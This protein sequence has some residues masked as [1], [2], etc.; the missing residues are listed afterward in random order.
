A[1]WSGS[2]AASIASCTATPAPKPYS[3]T[4]SAIARPPPSWNNPTPAITSSPPS[5]STSS[6]P[7]KNLCSTTRGPMPAPPSWSWTSTPAIQQRLL[8]PQRPDHRHRKD[9]PPRRKTSPRP[10]HGPQVAAG[11]RRE[12]SVAGTDPQTGLARRRFGEHL[13]RPG[14]S[15]GNADAGGGGLFRDRQRRESFVAAVDPAD[16]TAGPAHQR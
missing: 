7:P 12:F 2:K 8:H 11:R 5:I 10:A 1:A 13:F 14:G 6:A 3:S 4:T 16:R 9:R 15:V